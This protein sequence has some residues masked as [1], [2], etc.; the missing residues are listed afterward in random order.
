VDREGFWALDAPIVRVEAGPM[1]PPYAASLERAWLP[2][3]EDLTA[4]IRRL[5]DV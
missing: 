5:A 3:R 4:A 2:D 1:P